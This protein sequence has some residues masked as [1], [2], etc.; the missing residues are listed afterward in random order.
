MSIA[1]SDRKREGAGTR[2]G[3]TT[4]LGSQSQGM[5]AVETD[6]DLGIF[7][8]PPSCLF[9]EHICA[10]VTQAPPETVD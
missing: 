2:G 5:L 7:P 10:A 6:S 9:N 1:L 8:L 3:F 4:C